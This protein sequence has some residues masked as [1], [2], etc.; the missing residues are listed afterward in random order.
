MKHI[1]N[2][3]GKLY[4]ENASS[5]VICQD[6]CLYAQDD[7]WITINADEEEGR[8]GQH[9]LIKEDGSIVA[10]L[11]GKFKHLK[12]LNKKSKDGDT[13]SVI[14]AKQAVDYMTE[15]VDNTGFV[16]QFKSIEYNPVKRY[17]KQPSEEEI[18]GKLAGPDKTKGSCAS[19]ALCYVGQK[20]GMDVVDYRGGESQSFVSRARN[21]NIIIG[22]ENIVASDKSTNTISSGVKML[23]EID[24]YP[25][26]KEFIL[27]TGKHASIVR[28]TEEGRHQY[29]E[30]QSG[31]K[32]GWR[33]FRDTNGQFTMTTQETLRYR[34]GCQKSHTF[35]RQRIERESYLIDYDKLKN[36]KRFQCVL[37]AINT[38][39][40]QQQ[41]G[42][43]G[44]IK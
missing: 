2:I 23:K 35:M 21:Y 15:N 9:V 5:N 6:G 32:N 33:N 39:P 41:K 40:A 44:G 37:G 11:G 36:S 4:I 14:S 8:T 20:N 16:E 22:K 13:H 3:D 25:A 31:G 38:D 19:L 18:I 34:F 7:R 1:I 42:E 43:G 24:K 28:R 26:G 27:V 30:L 12:D 29:L 10:G 17:D